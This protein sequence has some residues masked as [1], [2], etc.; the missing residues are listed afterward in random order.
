MKCCM[1]R[2]FFCAAMAVL[3]GD[4]QEDTVFRGAQHPTTG[5]TAGTQKKDAERRTDDGRSP[6]LP[7]LTVGYR[8]RKLLHTHR[9]I[10]T[11]SGQVCAGTSRAKTRQGETHVRDGTEAVWVAGVLVPVKQVK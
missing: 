7:P 8:H 4:L 5:P 11:C 10:I 9:T 2:D 1:C 6:L 3:G